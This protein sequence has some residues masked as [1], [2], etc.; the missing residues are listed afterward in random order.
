MSLAR[1]DP[2]VVFCDREY[3]CPKQF[4]DGMHRAAAPLETMERIR[5]YFPQAGLTRLANITHF[6]R[7]QIPV[8]LAVRPNS[9]SIVT[10]SGKALTLEASLVSAAMESLEL[11]CAEIASPPSFLARYT[12]LDPA[13]AIP[14]PRLPIRSG[15][16]FSQQVPQRWCHAWDLL[17]QTRVVAP[18]DSVTMDFRCGLHDLVTTPF[19]MD[20]N[21]V[22]SGN[23]LLEA[24]CS[25]L[26]EVVERDATSC[27]Q[28]ASEQLGGL[29]P[30]VGLDTVEHP[31]ALEAVERFAKAGLEVFLFDTTVDTGIPVYTAYWR[32]PESGAVW[33]GQGAH[34]D[35]GVAMVRALTEAAQQN[36]VCIAGARD[37]L[38]GAFY[39]TIYFSDSRR[40][41]E[42]L[43]AHP[44]TVDAGERPSLATGTFEGDLAVALDLL[45]K[46]GLDQVLVWDLTPPGWEVAIV[47][48]LVPGL[49]GYFRR[50]YAPGA[51]ARAF[52]ERRRRLREEPASPDGFRPGIHL[53]A[54]GAP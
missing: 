19:R 18:Y 22:A 10:S 43:R 13:T 40:A 42:A 34:L 45:Q 51:R 3:R 20:S 9:R 31:R 8:T 4:T 38:Y 48:V 54:G 2:P 52:V 47:R 7:H 16:I 41:L 12:D 17:G 29:P 28:N 49:E 1:E 5:P 24:I 36:T 15:G 11:Y 53:P 21:G 26:F 30:R 14:A 37:D 39:D 44:V 6:D 50:C 25:G 33:A 23:H 32:E 27:H 46:A 35:P